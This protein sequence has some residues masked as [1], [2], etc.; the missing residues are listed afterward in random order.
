V[1]WLCRA[2]ALALVAGAAVLV[3]LT[4]TSATSISVAFLLADVVMGVLLAGL[5]TFAAP[6]RWARTP[7]FLTELLAVLV[8]TEVWTS[9][10][11]WVAV[12]V[13][14]PAIVAV[15]LIAISAK[16]PPRGD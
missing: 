2:Q 14:A 5:L 15:V 12:P 8:S 1:V 4:A 13:G 16:P 10:R 11:P 9:G 6:R 7:I 3:G